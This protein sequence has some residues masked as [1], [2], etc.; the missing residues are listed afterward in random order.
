MKPFLR[1]F[2]PRALTAILGLFFAILAAEIGLRVTHFEFQLYPSQ[3]Q[4]GYPDPITMQR[5]YEPD[6]DLFWVAHDYAAH[7]RAQAGQKPSLVF[8]GCSCTQFGVYDRF[9]AENLQT[10]CPQDHLTFVNVG[11]GGWTSY[12]GL[13]QLKRDV[14]PMQPRIITIYYGWNDH[15]CT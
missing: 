3:I 15:W 9:V 6:K 12:Q 1:T 2:L 8:M 13:Q 4:F 5:L 11:V 10:Q 14:L 7:V